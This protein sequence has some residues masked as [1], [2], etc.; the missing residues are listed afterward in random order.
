MDAF[1]KAVSPAPV[2]DAPDGVRN[3]LGKLPDTLVYAVKLYS[4]G[5]RSTQ[6]YARRGEGTP[7][8]GTAFV[9]ASSTAVLFSD[10]TFY[11]GPNAAEGDVKTIQL[12][13]LSRGYVYTSFLVSGK[14]LIAAWEEQRFFETGRTGILVTRIPDGVY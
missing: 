9:S 6:T 11:Y 14:S 7:L 10:G 5:T 8:E 1:Q 2:A 12:P 3:I 4:D 13:A